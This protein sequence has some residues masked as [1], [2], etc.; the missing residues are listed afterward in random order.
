MDNYAGIHLR[1]TVTVISAVNLASTGFT[2]SI[3]L[4]V[5]RSRFE[6]SKIGQECDSMYQYPSGCFVALAF[7]ARMC[8]FQFRLVA[9][10]GPEQQ[11]RFVSAGFAHCR[12]LL[13]PSIRGFDLRTRP[14][15]GGLAPL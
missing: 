11:R 9:S 6:R 5:S 13:P 4:A 1:R 14:L 8:P 15:L 7:V 3:S 12:L 2:G 10:R